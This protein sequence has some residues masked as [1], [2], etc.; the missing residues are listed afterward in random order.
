MSHTK[1]YTVYGYLKPRHTC[2]S[3]PV[4]IY[5]WRYVSG[6]WKSYSYVTAKASNY[7]AYTKY[8]GSLR[9]PDGEVG[10][11]ACLRAA[12]SRHPATWSSGFD[13]VTVK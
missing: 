7:S 9:L 11:A 12:D 6:V 2:G 13:Y 8:S 10:V 3:Y 5:K 1:Y 4:R